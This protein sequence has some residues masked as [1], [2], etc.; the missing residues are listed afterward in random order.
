MYIEIKLSIDDLSTKTIVPFWIISLVYNIVEHISPLAPYSRACGSYHDFFDRR[1]LLTKKLHVH[2][3][4]FLVVKLK[5]SLWKFYSLHHDLVNV[6]RYLCQRWP[7]LYSVC[8]NHIPVFVS[9]FMTC[10]LTFDKSNTTGGTSGA[11][12]A[13]PRSTCLPPVLVGFLLLT[14]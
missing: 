13:Y 1:L 5:S 7:L 11:E 4:G 2:N 8:H 12:I 10:K 14:F 3:Q 9:S 6:M